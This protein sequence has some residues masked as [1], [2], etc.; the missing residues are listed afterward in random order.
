MTATATRLTARQECS[1][2][3]VCT[4]PP[5]PAHLGTPATRLRAARLS[6]EEP[7]LT[8][9]WSWQHNQSQVA[10]HAAHPADGPARNGPHPCGP[11]RIPYFI[12]SNLRCPACPRTRRSCNSPGESWCHGTSL[13]VTARRA[14]VEHECYGHQVQKG[15]Q[16][17]RAHGVLPQRA[18][19]S[20]R[21]D[22]LPLPVRCTSALGSYCPKQ[23]H[24][25][26]GAA[27]STH[28][29]NTPC[30]NQLLPSGLLWSWST[31]S[32]S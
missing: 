26:P 2:A 30:C 23:Q 6:P 25:L 14:A 24:E 9:A 8:I 5:P 18:Q 16:L 10:L 31:R 15:P 12:P 28:P 22:K 3:I 32:L 27:P 20:V 21:A 7:D 13:V 1:K 4:K 17:A 19:S 29:I 11:C